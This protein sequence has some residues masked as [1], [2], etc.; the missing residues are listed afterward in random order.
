MVAAAVERW[1][2]DGIVQAER[3]PGCQRASRPANGPAPFLPRLPDDMLPG[4]LDFYLKDH[5]YQR[6]ED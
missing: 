3:Q 4:D 2:R 5:D 1:P 6:R